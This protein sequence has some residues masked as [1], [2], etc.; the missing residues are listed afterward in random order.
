MKRALLSILFCVIA[1]LAALFSMVS[2]FSAAIFGEDAKTACNNEILNSILIGGNATVTVEDGVCDNGLVVSGTY[3]VILQYREN[4]RVVEKILLVANNMAPNSLPPEI[5]LLEPN[6]LLI[7]APK[8]MVT[9][10]GPVGAAGIQFM[11]QFK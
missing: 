11:Y 9:E 8:D 2:Y 1:L 4:E 5:K 3:K 7:I 10:K 6:S